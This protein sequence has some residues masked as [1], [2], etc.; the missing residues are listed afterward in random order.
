MAPTE[1]K[2][3]VKTLKEENRV[4][5]KELAEHRDKFRTLLAWGGVGVVRCGLARVRVGRW[6]VTLHEGHRETWIL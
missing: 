1:A 4:M 2:E 3:A 5:K 6:E